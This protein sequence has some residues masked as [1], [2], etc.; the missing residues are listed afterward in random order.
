M[1]KPVIFL[2]VILS[3]LT[4]QPA[5]SFTQYTSNPAPSPMG[6]EWL[7][8]LGAEKILDLKKLQTQMGSVQK[9]SDI[10][11]NTDEVKRIYSNKVDDV[12]FQSTYMAIFSAIIGQRFVD[13]AGTRVGVTLEGRQCFDAVAQEPVSA[14]IDH[15]MRSPND[16]NAV[17]SVDAI[18][19]A[20]KK[21]VKVFVDAAMAAPKSMVVQDGGILP[22]PVT[23]ESNY[24]LFGRAVHLFQDSFSLDHVVRLPE[25]DFKQVRN[26]K[27]YGCTAGVEE[28][29]HKIIQNVILNAS[30]GDGSGT[31]KSH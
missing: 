1:L 23:V 21:F 11:L 27:G 8:R 31:M 3:L 30:A 2:S 16:K 17:G 22:G 20:R 15:F 9:L 12:R 19:R 5:F 4:T 18:K 6:H 29:N 25:D 14:Y 24:F 28:H 13:F 26:L 7:T 10:P